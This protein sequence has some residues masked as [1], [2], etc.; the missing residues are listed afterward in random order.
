MKVSDK[1]IV[2][3]RFFLLVLLAGCSAFAPKPAGVP[4]EQIGAMAE[5]IL[6]AINKGDYSS[7]KA[8]LSDQML[9]AM[10]ESEFTKM[11]AMLANSSGKYVSKGA[12][13]LSNSQGFAIYRFPAKFEKEDVTVTLVFAVNGNKVDGLFFDSPA[14]RATPQPT[15]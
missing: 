12:A 14:L 8:D 2:S 9:Q 6:Q 15:K 4:A 7:F 11:Q 3:Y 5:N 1:L 13:Q 10:P